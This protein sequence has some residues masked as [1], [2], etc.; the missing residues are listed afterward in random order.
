[1]STSRVSPGVK[2]LGGFPFISRTFEGK[3][4]D[5]PFVLD[6]DANLYIGPA[7]LVSRDEH[8][9]IEVIFHFLAQTGRTVYPFQEMLRNRRKLLE[10]FSVFDDVRTDDGAEEF[11]LHIFGTYDG[12]P[13]HGWQDDELPAGPCGK[14]VNEL[15]RRFYAICERL[16]PSFAKHA[17]DEEMKE[18]EGR[19][20]LD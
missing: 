11:T 16:D 17:L 10:V 20:L 8:I 9:V 7:D 12:E 19:F 18:V 1:M 13:L 6:A 14:S 2:L 5:N 4:K 15:K 3:F